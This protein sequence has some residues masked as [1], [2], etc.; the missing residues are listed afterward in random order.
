MYIE[1]PEW[2]ETEKNCILRRKGNKSAREDMRK[3]KGVII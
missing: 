2:D 1:K 3:E